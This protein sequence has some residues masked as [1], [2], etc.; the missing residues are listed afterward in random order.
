[1]QIHISYLERAKADFEE[2]LKT[3]AGRDP[4]NY[5]SWDELPLEDQQQLIVEIVA[6][7]FRAEEKKAAA[8]ADE[9]ERGEY[10]AEVLK[11]ADF[12]QFV[13]THW[14]ADHTDRLRFLRK[15]IAREQKLAAKEDSFKITFAY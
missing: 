12:R 3:E 1:M 4:G 7:D 5:T 10:M 8:I 15:E 14:L 11:D 2:W 9:H 13:A 6:E